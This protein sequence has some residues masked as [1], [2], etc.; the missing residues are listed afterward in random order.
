MSSMIRR[1]KRE[2]SFAV[3]RNIEDEK[4]ILKKEIE[5]KALKDQKNEDKKLIAQLCEQSRELQNEMFA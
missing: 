2:N 4:E 5:E 3:R 1:I